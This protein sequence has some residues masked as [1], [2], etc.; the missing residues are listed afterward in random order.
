MTTEM[1]NFLLSHS[2]VSGEH[3]GHGPLAL[4]LLKFTCTEYLVG[5]YFKSV[6]HA[7]QMSKPQ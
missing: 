2:C 7:A 1:F 3:C 5:I 4:S 6:I